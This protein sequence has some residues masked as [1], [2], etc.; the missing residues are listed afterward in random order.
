MKINNII[1]EII[2]NDIK[3]MGMLNEYS[4]N[5]KH[6]SADKIM[7]KLNENEE[8]KKLSEQNKINRDNLSY[9]LQNSTILTSVVSSSIIINEGM[10]FNATSISDVCTVL[11]LN[12]SSSLLKLSFKFSINSLLLSI[13]YIS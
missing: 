1:N 5:Y 9:Y 4:E 8:Y 3:S 2:E 6:L 13:I 7:D 11:K 10:F 12:S